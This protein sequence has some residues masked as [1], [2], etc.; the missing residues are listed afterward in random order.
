MVVA[1]SEPGG[2]RLQISV[3][4]IGSIEKWARARC[5]GSFR[6]DANFLR[7][8]LCRYIYRG[9]AVIVMDWVHHSPQPFAFLC[10]GIMHQVMMQSVRILSTVKKLVI[11]FSDM[12]NRFKFL[13]LYPR[14]GKLNGGRNWL[15]FYLS[16]QWIWRTLHRH[17]SWYL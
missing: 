7:Q 13:R 15:F 16:F 1:A 5:W 6:K 9:R 2:V 4:P 3:L 14:L 17:Y 8:P 12:P 11:L 10:F